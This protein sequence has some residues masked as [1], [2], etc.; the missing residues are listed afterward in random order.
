MTG[1]AIDLV[2]ND[3]SRSMDG[4]INLG[5][6]VLA[7]RVTDHE[8]LVSAEPSL[9]RAARVP[10][11]Y[12]HSRLEIAGHWSNIIIAMTGAA[13]TRARVSERASERAQSSRGRDG[14]QFRACDAPRERERDRITLLLP[15]RDRTVAVSRF[16][17]FEEVSLF[18]VR[19]RSDFRALRSSKPAAGITWIYFCVELCRVSF[20][21]VV[22]G[23]I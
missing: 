3:F 13:R 1:H 14:R 21:P 5:G 8:P 15:R 23:V 20:A 10:V 7:S 18:R 17:A 22:R 2:E 11:V 6:S 16:P 4:T 19:T 12:F 9:L